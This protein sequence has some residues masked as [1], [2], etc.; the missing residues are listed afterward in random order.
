MRVGNLSLEEYN[1]HEPTICSAFLTYRVKRCTSSAFSICS[2]F[3][4]RWHV[5][6][7]S[8]VVLREDPVFILVLYVNMPHYIGISRSEVLDI[9]GSLL[10]LRVHVVLYTFPLY[11]LSKWLLCDSFV[12]VLWKYNLR[13]YISIALTRSAN[14][15]VDIFRAADSLNTKR[16]I[17]VDVTFMFD[18]RKADSFIVEV[19][20]CILLCP[21]VRIQQEVLVFYNRPR[22]VALRCPLAFLRDCIRIDGWDSRVH[23]ISWE[24]FDNSVEIFVFFL[25]RWVSLGSF[26]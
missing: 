21:F 8:S 18:H 9:S 11:I 25:C 7:E 3:A 22:N 14:T 16:Q 4:Q 19:P 13:L 24:L 12:V 10:Q 20:I 15:S 5:F 23:I 2:A 17:R 26:S 1:R 6:I